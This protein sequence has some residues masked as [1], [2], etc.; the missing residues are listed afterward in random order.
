VESG[1]DTVPDTGY[2]RLFYLPRS[3]RVVNF[4]RL[5]DPPLP[6]VTLESVMDAGPRALKTSLMRDRKRKAETYA[7]VASMLRTFDEQA[8]Q[9]ANP[10]A[11][12]RRDP[13]PLAEAIVGSW[14]NGLLV[15][16]FLPDGTM[17]MGSPREGGRRRG[18]WWIGADGRLHATE[19]GRGSRGEWVTDAWVAGD[20]MTIVRDGTGLT[21]RR[22]S[23]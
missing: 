6:E 17:T 4:E 7:E 10:P 12:D 16:G 14:S 5:P 1:W 21:F 23:R 2:V 3:R 18:R 8:H 11:P 19:A 9:A 13:R 22:L 15:F 20:E